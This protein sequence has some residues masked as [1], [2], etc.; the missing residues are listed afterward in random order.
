MKTVKILALFAICIFAVSCNKEQAPAPEP[1]PEAPEVY[2]PQN[3]QEFVD[4]TKVKT[5]NYYKAPKADLSAA[6]V[7]VTYDEKVLYQPI[8]IKYTYANGDTYTYTIPAEFG[9]WANEAGRL[10]VVTDKQNT[11]WLQG[12]T[13]TGKFCEFVFYGDPAFNGKKIRPNSYR[14]LPAGE[15][16]YR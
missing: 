15:I 4:L 11:V 10:R 1:V 6:S 12:Q 7:A 9:L 3:V 16:V 2:Q 14:N 5:Y 8:K 13:K